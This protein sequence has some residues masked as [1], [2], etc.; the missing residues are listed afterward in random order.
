MAVSGL[1]KALA[2]IRE[3]HAILDLLGHLPIRIN[4][5]GHGF[6]SCI[7]LLLRKNHYPIAVRNDIVSRINCH[8][9]L[10]TVELDWYID[11]SNLDIL[12][13]RRSD[14]LCKDLLGPCQSPVRPQQCH[15]VT[16]YEP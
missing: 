5:F 3:A 16:I 6:D 2:R 15:G 8:V 10:I 13:W 12:G 14:V 1:S 7:R 11:R 4:L 9:R